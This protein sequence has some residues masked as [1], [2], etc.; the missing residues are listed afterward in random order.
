MW[1]CPRCGVQFVNRNQWHSCRRATL[2]DWLGGLGPAGMALYRRFVAIIEACGDYHV[3]P[4]KTRIAFL[5]QVRFASITR[6]RD[7]AMV[8]SFALPSALRSP[9]LARVEE[10]VPEWFVHTLVVT[11]PEELDDEVQKWMRESYRLMGMR[12]RLRGRRRVR[13]RD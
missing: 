10:V 2:D 13:R 1:V 11:A 4:A 6:L 5:G 3:A 12:E 9:R 7:D 8:C